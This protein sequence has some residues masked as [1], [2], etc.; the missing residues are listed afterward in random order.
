MP[1][2]TERMADFFF[3]FYRESWTLAL[4]SIFKPLE[5]TDP[6]SFITKQIKHSFSSEIHTYTHLFYFL[7]SQFLYWEQN[8][9]PK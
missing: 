3:Q 9:M 2:L 1:A 5:K 6:K 8:K 4:A 7:F